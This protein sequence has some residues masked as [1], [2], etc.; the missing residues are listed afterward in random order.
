MAAA[1]V[2][3]GINALSDQALITISIG[4]GLYEEL[5]FRMLGIA[6]LHIIFVDL[7]RMSDKW[8]TGLA[9]LI[10]AA[11]FAVYHDVTAPSGDLQITKALS[12]LC[13]GGYFGLLYIFRGFG[14]VVGVHA[15]YDIAVLVGLPR[16]G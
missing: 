16:L 13:A 10:S 2:V 15:L 1:Q 11:A 4:A 9:I 8:G 7:A 12:L 5:L 3:P 6:L 14:I